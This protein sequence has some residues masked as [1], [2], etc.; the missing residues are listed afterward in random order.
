M[1]NSLNIVY[2]CLSMLMRIETQKHNI[3]RY[4]VAPDSSRALCVKSTLTYY[5]FLSLYGMQLLFTHPADREQHCHSAE[6]VFLV[7]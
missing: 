1:D 5:H 4:R 3:V 2:H 7:T 6:I